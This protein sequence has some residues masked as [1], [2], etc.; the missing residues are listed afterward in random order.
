MIKNV[1]LDFGHGGIGADGKYTTAPKKMHRFSDGT[2]AYEG[3]LN[4][5]IGGHIYTC[6]RSHSELN[7][8]T[9]VRE[10]DPRDLS[11]SYRV[12]VANSFDPKSTIFVS[13]HCNASPNHN[14][15]GFE[16]Y[17]TKG[18]T[19]SDSLAESIANSAEYALDRESVRT[20]YDLSDGDKDKEAD[21]YVLRKT[22]C[23]AVLLECGFFDFRKDF[24]LLSDPLF[25]GD[26]GSW[27]YT[28]IINYINEQNK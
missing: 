9:T 20:R 19:K 22:K 16:L 26:L 5:Q 28:G 7:I 1:I 8:V 11:L 27:I 14:A 3:V 21:F 23:P 17:T 12:R 24:E 10:D 13:V 18:L 15:G 2:V 4:R 25:Q 6:L